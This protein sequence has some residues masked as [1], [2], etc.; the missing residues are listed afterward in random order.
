MEQP[1][2]KY[3]KMVIRS[4]L[5]SSPGRVTI[6]QILNEYSN[7][8]GCNLPYKHLGFNTVFELLENM[9]DVLKVP[10]NP[11]MNSL[12]TLIVDEK[13][14]HLRELVVNQKSKKQ[15]PR[16]N[17]S[18]GRSGNNHLLKS[19]NF[20]SHD[21]NHNNHRPDYSTSRYKNCSPSYDYSARGY[22]YSN[23]N[24]N[25]ARGYDHVKTKS[26]TKPIGIVTPN[27]RSFIENLCNT[28]GSEM[29]TI[30]KLKNCLIN[31]PDYNK[32]GTTNI[33]ESINMLKFFIY[34]DKGG[35]HLKD[36]PLEIFRS[37]TS[38]KRKYTIP[39]SA[40]YLSS[41]VDD[42]EELLYSEINNDDYDYEMDYSSL[43]NLKVHENE[44]K[45]SQTSTRTAHHDNTILSS[46]SNSPQHSDSWQKLRTYNSSSQPNG[47]NRLDPQNMVNM[48]KTDLNGSKSKSSDTVS[49]QN[50]D[51]NTFISSTKPI[52]NK[53]VS[54]IEHKENCDIK[55]TPDS[56]KTQ[57]DEYKKAIV[58]IIAESD[59]PITVNNVLNKFK[60]KHGY[61]FPF[62][63]FSCVTYM[64]FFRLYPDMFKL[65]NQCSTNSVVSLQKQIICKRKETVRKYLSKASIFNNVAVVNSE[66]YILDQSKIISELLSDDDQKIKDTAID[67]SCQP[68][69][70][71]S[72]NSYEIYDADTILDTMKVKMRQIL[73]KYKDG[74]LC[75]DFMNVYG[76]AYNSHF[77]FSEYGFS[78]M[79]DMAYKLPS[80]FYVKVTEDNNECILF[81]AHRRSELENNSDDPSLYYKNIPKTVL[82]NLSKFFDKY[83]TGVKF[84]ELLTLYCA[85]YGRAYEP[86]KYGYSSEKHM[87]ECLDKMVEIE[88]NE[89]FTINPYAYTKP[90]QDLDHTDNYDNNSIAL[91]D[92]DFLL[93]Y[94]GNDV[95]NGRFK[96][97]KVKFNIKELTN[98]IVAEIFNPSSFYI[99]LAA[100]VNN[101]NSLMDSLQ[102]YYN[103]NEKKF[104]VL[105]K[106]ILQG[107]ACTS[108]FEDSGLWHRATVL[109]IIDDENVQLLYVDYGSIEI[110]PKT[111]VRL[112]AS[113]FGIY[114]AQGVHC[115][116][117]EYNELNYPREISES[118][119]EMVD[120]HVLEAQFHS[121]VSEDDS[122]KK[123]VTLFMNTQTSKININKKC[124]KEILN[125][126]SKHQESVRRMICKVM[127]EETEETE[128]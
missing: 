90:V 110:V 21:Y 57:K 126:L 71:N 109:K 86:L 104:K 76:S 101:L 116:L 47:Q 82:Y 83:R 88:N 123:T 49:A 112:L 105:P 103:E 58:A 33:E 27:L 19:S 44:Q 28:S 50:I 5:T 102:V 73:S 23:R 106:L 10:S 32:L 111:N 69:C 77:N 107:L 38:D 30:N 41:I 100:E 52:H 37:K 6:S 60:K 12:I 74:I 99:Q 85:E 8:E 54:K 72:I 125:H 26:Y 119:A 51:K 9:N 22:E 25:S 65:E 7:Y 55:N 29:I 2:L 67:N 117:Y 4:L 34:I 56:S 92:T 13:T 78:S 61:N 62:Q 93:H 75:N 118:F 128:V 79:R 122:E 95:C 42:N 40:S 43:E 24:G 80:V 97:S 36:S 121:Q 120:D 115:G 127:A 87:F 59:Q 46:S 39:T 89:L 68:H 16:R 45:V 81:E 96:Y 11:N 108:C 3:L 98:V 31:H 124:S 64:D 91:P 14:S 84:N 66:N 15:R 53:I 114:P 35:V 17:Y 113:Q 20:K 18:S 70:E 94:S 48:F 1:D 63:E